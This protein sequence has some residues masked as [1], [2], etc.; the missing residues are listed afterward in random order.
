MFPQEGRILVAQAGSG[1]EGEAV[2]EESDL[3]HEEIRS[4]GHQ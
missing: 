3:A 4:R 2:G 1:S